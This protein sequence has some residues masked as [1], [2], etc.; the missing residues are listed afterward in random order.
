MSL[1]R[2]VMWKAV[3]GR[4]FL[5]DTEELKLNT[6]EELLQHIAELRKKHGYEEPTFMH[7]SGP[8]AHKLDSIDTSELPDDLREKVSSVIKEGLER[9]DPK[10]M[11]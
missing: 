7:L 2:R 6:Q 1:P 11:N 5:I 9:P 10:T 3:D 4:E 8:Q